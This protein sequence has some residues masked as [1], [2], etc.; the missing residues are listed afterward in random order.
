MPSAFS[1]LSGCQD[2]K[3]ERQNKPEEPI[4]Q[5]KLTTLEDRKRVDNETRKYVPNRSGDSRSSLRQ[6][7]ARCFDV[8]AAP[9][10]SRSPFGTSSGTLSVTG[11]K[12]D[13]LHPPSLAFGAIRED[14]IHREATFGDDLLEQEAFTAL[15]EVLARSLDRPAVFVTEFAALFFLVGH[16]F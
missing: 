11:A 4:G 13:P 9:E 10:P 16:D 3:T 14:L 8:P 6:A 15:A 1:R 12:R 5:V 7:D 2:R